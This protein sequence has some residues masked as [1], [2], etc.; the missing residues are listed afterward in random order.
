VMDAGDQ[1]L[2]IADGLEKVE[3]HSDKVRI[4]MD[5]FGRT[6]GDMLI[7]MEQGAEGIRLAIKEAELL[8]IT[9]K[10]EQGAMVEEANDAMTK[11]GQIAKGAF[12]Q[13]TIALAPFV[14][15][16][17]DSFTEM[18]LS[19]ESM[20]DRVTAAMRS[21]VQ[22]MGFLEDKTVKLRGIFKM[23]SAE[24]LEL[25][26]GLKL[27]WN[28]PTALLEINDPKP[29][30]NLGQSK[31]MEKLA[32]ENPERFA[33]MVQSGKFG[34]VF[35]ETDIERMAVDILRE[36]AGQDWGGV[37]GKGIVER[38]DD[39]IAE[40][41]QRVKQGAENRVGKALEKA[42]GG[43][44]GIGPMTEA[45]WE[46]ALLRSAE[47]AIAPAMAAKALKAVKRATKGL[48]KNIGAGKGIGP[49][50]E[51]QWETDLL[52]DLDPRGFSPR[53][54][55]PEWQQVAQKKWLKMRGLKPLKF[56]QIGE[57]AVFKREVESWEVQRLRELDRGLQKFADPSRSSE[58]LRRRRAT[59][60]TRT[61]ERFRM[62]QQRKKLEDQIKA[63]RQRD[64]RRKGKAIQVEMH[65]GKV[66]LDILKSVNDIRDSKFVSFAS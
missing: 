24:V 33:A 28:L 55:A 36:G 62:R 19:G 3:N 60:L 17:A 31:A 16:W 53:E 12:N 65:K 6:G 20:A 58:E 29:A 5:I 49:M 32:F 51:A 45:Q 38:F 15:K 48:E 11:L 61:E 43:G 18:S 10:D 1:F 9:F 25:T 64:E 46:V 34:Q 39:A 44:K 14:T 37:Q 4:A 2:A 26:S 41:K 40:N 66:L 59:G 23:F 54:A 42:I 30:M 56:A 50:T 8:G 57:A 52:K 63:R 47:P 7:T 27:L 35:S 22:G 13:I 21:I